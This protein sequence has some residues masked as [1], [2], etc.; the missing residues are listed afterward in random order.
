MK[1]SPSA[2]GQVSGSFVSE[3]LWTGTLG[4][5]NALP[6]SVVEASRQCQT[7][8]DFRRLLTPG[9]AQAVRGRSNSRPG[10]HGHPQDST[11]PVW[12]PPQLRGLVQNRRGHIRSGLVWRKPIWGGRGSARALISLSS[13]AICPLCLA[14]LEMNEVPSGTY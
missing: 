6:S 12:H 13:R 2:S 9:S 14:T 5:S 3:E 1:V 7:H 4:S 10:T 11:R 8:Q